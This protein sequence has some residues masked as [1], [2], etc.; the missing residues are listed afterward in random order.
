MFDARAALDAILP[1]LDRGDAP[2]SKWPDHNGEYWALCPFHHDRSTGT[3]SVSERGYKCFSCGAKGGLTKL[4]ERLKVDLG[5][6]TVARLS[7][8]VTDGNISLAQYAGTKRLA[9]DFL[10]TTFSVSERKRGGRVSLRLPYMDRDG[11]ET[12]V[13]YR[14][15]LTGDKFRWATCSKLSLYGLWRL[16]PA[17]R[18]VILVE[19]E[20]DTQTLVYHGIAALGVPGATNWQPAWA[21]ELAGRDVYAWQEPDAAGAA[22][23][24]RIGADIPELRVIAAP[25]GYKDVS[26]AHIAGEDVPALIARLKSEAR[27]FAR[28][29]AETLDQ[30]ARDA[31]RTAGDLLVA[32]SILTEFGALCERLGLVGEDRLA[33]LLYLA[34]TT[35]LLERPVSVA[36]KGPS[37]GGKSF[38][39]ETVLR[40][41]PASAYY[42]LSSMSERALAYS[43]EPLVHRFLVLFEAAGVTGDFA[44]Y[45]VR[46]LLSEGCIR[47]ETVE[48]TNEGMQ[49]RLI[50][51][52]G[53]TGLLV[54]TTWASLHPENETRLLSLTVRDDRAQ[55]ARVLQALADRA[56]GRSPDEVDLTAWH[57]VQAWLALAGCRDV[58]IPYAHE[59]AAASDPRAVR[60]RRDF[61]AVLNL[62]RGHA[63]LHQKTRTRDERGRIV[64]T[65]VD[66]AAVYDLVIDTV[67][68][69][70]QAS[71]SPMI[72]ETV[73]AVAEIDAETGLPVTYTK[74]AERLGIDK[75]AAQRR[76]SVAIRDGYLINA[77]DKKGRPAKL[78][79][80]E[81]LPE[82]R[83][84]LPHPAD[85]EINLR[86][87]PP[88]NP[89]TVQP[90]DEP[91]CTEPA[92]ALEVF[93]L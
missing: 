58:T 54:T 79:A 89:A 72:R 30:A 57:A 61:A 32:P 6:C 26:A 50:E 47:Y 59:L 5:G 44:T 12:A 84:V 49:P 75:S 4:A 68:E 8:G 71:V 53:P 82:E 77:E 76:A 92:W 90:L 3:F 10:K 48:K 91:A 18:D 22:F 69:G 43:E 46:T 29:Q 1:H 11:K 60:L 39:V 7:E 42:A 51:R 40:A 37:S 17:A 55:T 63:I 2:S 56:N 33:R 86:V 13:R 81:P 73:R 85:L 83:A 34:L 88:V 66:Y 41:F 36:V 9:V 16:D 62:V 70:V 28:I 38:T 31:E 67:S 52:A 25:A 27:P 74:L 23:I 21:A 80:G 78:T 15:A 14:I 87:T 45:L 24:Q 19:G 65:L 64:A 35:R 20:S 93:E